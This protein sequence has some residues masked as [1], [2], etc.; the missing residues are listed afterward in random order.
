MP[1]SLLLYFMQGVILREYKFVLAPNNGSE[2]R[3]SVQP[4]LNA[5]KD[6]WLTSVGLDVCE[7]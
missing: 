7:K 2:N 4:V 5:L 6:E 1:Y 3:F